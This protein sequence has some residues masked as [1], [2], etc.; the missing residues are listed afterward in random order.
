MEFEIESGWDVSDAEL[1]MVS[2]E[3]DTIVS[4]TQAP[5]CIQW[6]SNGTP[7]EGVTA[8][9]VDVGSGLLENDYGRKN[10]EGKVVLASGD[11][12]AEGNDHAYSLAMRFGAIGLVT[13]SLLYPQPP[14]RTR[15]SQP[16]AVQM[17]RTPKLGKGWAFSISYTKAQTLRR[18]LEQGP[19][20][21]WALVD[22][23]N[24]RGKDH[25]LI[26]E[27]IGAEK[28]DEEVW[29]VAHCSGTKPGANCAAGVGLWLEQARLFTHLVRTERISRPKRTIRFILGAEGLGINAYLDRLGEK[30]PKVH[31]AFVYCSVGNDQEKCNS[32][33]VMFKSPE[34]IPSY[35]NHICQY[36]IEAASKD[37]TPPFKDAS[38]DLV[39]IRSN[40]APYT[41][42]SDNSTL[43]RFKIPCP[44]FMSWPDTHFHTQFLTA[45][46]ID[47]RILGRCGLITSYVGLF[48]ADA[49]I[50]EARAML[51]EVKRRE[52]HELL[53]TTTETY[54]ALLAV[55]GSRVAQGNVDAIW[56]DFE[57]KTKYILQRALGAI[58]ALQELISS[59][60]ELEEFKAQCSSYQQ[61]LRRKASEEQE[62]LN[63]LAKKWKGD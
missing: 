26:G 3:E 4:Y 31:C 50:D 19:V 48:I 29:F 39:L 24:Y 8:E 7:K 49:G 46:K 12:H 45:D 28:P 22:A 11:G 30:I 1:R 25:V 36:A 6:W 32:S 14:T 27:V 23:R 5:T 53:S 58:N 59:K 54:H 62:F 18:L 57:K 15:V 41:P 34:S 21:V 55:N 35:V 37:A 42:W 10:V 2:P 9:L 60:E 52:E 47:S 13:D 56:N 63:S 20:T 51:A 38:R 44:L 40:V 61:T 17:L 16:E 43:M 33:L